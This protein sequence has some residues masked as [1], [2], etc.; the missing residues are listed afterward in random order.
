M[1][2]NRVIPLVIFAKAP[3][4]GQVKTR[5]QPQLTPRESADVARL[6]LQI[7]IHKAVQ[8]WPGEIIL[9]AGLDARHPF[10]VEMATQHQLRIETQAEGDLGQRM[11][12][13]MQQFGYP[14]AIIGSDIPQINEHVLKAA[15]TYLSSGN[16]V[17]GPS[18]DGGYYLIGLARANPALFEKILW[19][20]N[21]V[22]EQTLEKARTMSLELQQLTP[23]NDVDTWSDLN[24]AAKE[25]PQLR[26]YLDS[27]LP[28]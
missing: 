21:K 13:A 28:A 14:V 11:H 22:L 16:N 23:I 24:A 5:L 20:S 4:P 3:I 15:H 7:T 8:F 2:S 26:R 1:E 27:I 17:L 6:L 19:G 25:V 9:S 12:Q 10:L 18:D